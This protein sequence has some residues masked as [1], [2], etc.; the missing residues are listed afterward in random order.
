MLHIPHDAVD[1]EGVLELAPAFIQDHE[2]TRLG[3][4]AE[5]RV[6]VRVVCARNRKL[7]EMVATLDTP[8][9]S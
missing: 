5:V 8:G 1:D 2:F 9:R 3:G 7:E 6:D 4:N